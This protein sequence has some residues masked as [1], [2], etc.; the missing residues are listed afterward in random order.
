MK[1]MLTTTP[2]SFGAQNPT[3]PHQE[4]SPDAIFIKDFSFIF[5]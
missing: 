2:S 3:Y 1:F 4:P 5:V